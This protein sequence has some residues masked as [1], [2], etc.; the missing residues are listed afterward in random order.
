MY[1]SRSGANRWQMADFLYDG[2]SNV[3]SIS[4]HFYVIF[5]NKIKCKKAWPWKWSLSRRRK[6]RVAPFHVRFYIRYFFNF[7]YIRLCQRMHTQWGIQRETGVMTI[8]KICTADFPNEAAAG[9]NDRQVNMYDTSSTIIDSPA[10]TT[11][12]AN[13]T[14]IQS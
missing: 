9:A 14:I 2:N 12:D 10:E 6:T 4:H 1:N 3:C 11:I 8:G 7:S 13:V 5:A